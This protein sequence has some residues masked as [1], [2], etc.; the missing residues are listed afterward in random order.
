MMKQQAESKSNNRESGYGEVGECTVTPLE[1]VEGYYVDLKGDDGR[2]YRSILR[3]V[4]CGADKPLN[5][6]IE[7]EF[8]GFEFKIDES[9]LHLR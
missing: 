8:K 2:W 3:T 7:M 1:D 9:E 5:A 6:T 4:Y